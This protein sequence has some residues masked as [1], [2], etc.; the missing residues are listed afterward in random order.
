MKIKYFLI[1]AFGFTGSVLAQDNTWRGL[2]IEKENR[3]SPYNRSEDYV[4]SQVI[5][6]QIVESL[7]NKI[8]SPY[9]GKFFKSQEE[10][11]IEHI[12]SLSEAHDS[13]LCSTDKKTK[14]R[15]A[16]DIQNLT[17]ASPT[18]N[19]DEKSGHDASGWLPEKNK[20][21]F[22]NRVI[23]VKKAY[24]LTVD[25]EELIALEKVISQCSSFKMVV[26]N[27]P[28]QQNNKQYTVTHL[29]EPNVK[30]SRSGICHWRESSPYYSMTKHYQPFQDVQ[31]CLRSG[32][33][34]PKRDFKCQNSINERKILYKQASVINSEELYS[35]QSNINQGN[36]PNVKK[37]KSGICHSKDSSS[38]YSRT[39]NFTPYQSLELCLNSGGRCPKRDFKCQS[40]TVNQ[41]SSYKGKTISHIQKPS[42]E[43]SNINQGNNPNVKK[44]KS[45]ICHSKDSSSSYSRT[46]NFTAY[47]SLELCLKSGG[48]CPKRDSICNNIRIPASY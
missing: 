2:K 28:S 18:V 29:H 14:N 23:E 7:G 16:S 37:S 10:T 8:Y 3:C 11:D 33:R 6:N 39:K 1:F 36:S 48:R 17:L 19:R 41:A 34:C 44:S 31:S 32:G 9:S 47:Q 22:A 40:I 46:K 5:E 15:F 30:K 42:F 12:V 45:G 4:Y 21:W 43:Q 13:G 20:C 35:K 38:S 26:F 27:E 25:S 24:D